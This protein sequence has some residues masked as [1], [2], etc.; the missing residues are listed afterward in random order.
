MS[1]RPDLRERF[2]LEHAVVQ[3][4]LGG[5]L[6]GPELAAAV[7]LAGGLGTLGISVQPEGYRKAIR[8]ARERAPGKPIAANLLLPVMRREHV[9]VCVEERVPIVSLFFGFDRRAVDAL[10]QAGCLVLHQIGTLEQAQRAL[11]EGADGLV[12]QGEAAGGHVLATEPLSSIL[13]RV[14]ELAGERPVLAAG[15]IHDR[16]SAA[17]AIA[18]GADGVWVGTRFLLT[19]ESAAHDA[20]KARLLAADSTL[21]TLLFGLGWH[22]LHRVVPNAATRRWCER[23]ALGPLWQRA[24]SRSLEPLLRALPPGGVRHLLAR[25]RVGVPFYS[26][27]ALLRGMD[28]GLAEVTPLYAGT[29]VEHITELRSAADVVRELAAGLP[30]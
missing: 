27:A 3:A 16:A 11:A 7:A 22:G 20:Y 12:V 6:A 24:I 23:D 13:P 28:E 18:L 29:C 1:V 14:R 10:H 25:Q 5:G 2:G 15:G 30:R 8:R 21:Q 19:H 26:P 9:Q 4:P 17:A